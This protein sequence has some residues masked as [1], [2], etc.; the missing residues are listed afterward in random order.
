MTSITVIMGVDPAT[1]DEG[2]WGFSSE[3]QWIP[4]VCADENRLRDIYP[5]AVEM[6]KEIGV[7]FRVVQFDKRNDVTEA[8]AKLYS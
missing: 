3:G 2:V 4:M 7:A 8:V 1:G 5:I 6:S